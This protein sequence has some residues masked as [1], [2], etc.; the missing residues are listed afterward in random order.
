MTEQEVEDF[1]DYL[2]DVFMIWDCE[3]QNWIEGMPVILRFENKDVVVSKTQ[4]KDG[5]QIATLSEDKDA[6]LEYLQKER[7]I[8]ERCL[9]WVRVSCY[10]NCIGEL[11]SIESLLSL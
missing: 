3:E 2:A 5:F 1:E 9:S 4:G 7:S 8:Q 6:L 11:T 10:S